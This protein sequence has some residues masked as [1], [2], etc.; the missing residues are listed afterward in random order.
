MP[1]PDFAFQKKLGVNEIVYG[2]VEFLQKCILRLF[3]CMKKTNQKHGVSCEFFRLDFRTINFVE[4]TLQEFP[5]GS[6]VLHL[7]WGSKKELKEK[8][9]MEIS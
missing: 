6:Y 1:E 5:F 2:D 7:K 9:G 8:N 3:E 4:E